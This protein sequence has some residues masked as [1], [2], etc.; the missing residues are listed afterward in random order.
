MIQGEKVAAIGPSL[1]ALNHWTNDLWVVAILDPSRSVDSKY[2]RVLI[3]TD[4]DEV[5]A[6]LKVRETEKEIEIITTDGRIQNIARNSIQEEKESILS[7]MPDG[8]EKSL[9]PQQMADV[10]RYLRSSK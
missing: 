2:R 4:S 1:E 5:I 8:F 3:R 6:G 9:S 7:L 10:V